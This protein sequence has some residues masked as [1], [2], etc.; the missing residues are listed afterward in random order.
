MSQLS[1]A[2]WI[3]AYFQT[4]GPCWPRCRLFPRFWA[5]QF[6]HHLLVSG[7]VCYHD[8]LAQTIGEASL[9]ITILLPFYRQRV[10]DHIDSINTVFPVPD[11]G[12]SVVLSNL[13]HLVV[14]N[15][16]Y[17]TVAI[18]SKML[19]FIWCN[20]YSTWTLSKEVSPKRHLEGEIPVEISAN[21][22]P[23]AIT[24]V[25]LSDVGLVI[26]SYLVNVTA[27]KTVNS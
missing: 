22:E 21:A 13:L 18:V 23:A 5:G 4:T 8:C 25:L 19:V 6:C 11:L 17:C 24:F 9:L 26:S 1:L 2:E 10:T 14:P 12:V 27:C 20:T 7:R 15:E 3:D 16:L